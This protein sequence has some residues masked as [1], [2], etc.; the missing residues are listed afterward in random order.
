MEDIDNFLKMN[1]RSGLVDIAPL[2]KELGKR[3]H[4]KCTGC[5]ANAFFEAFSRFVRSVLDGDIKLRDN[6]YRKWMECRIRCFGRYAGIAEPGIDGRLLRDMN[7]CHDI[8]KNGIMEPIVFVRESD[9]F[10][11]D[12]YHRMVVWHELGN[13]EIRYLEG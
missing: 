7:L 9:G 1:A 10:E 2:K 6:P 4:S 3:F 13:D 12:G 5:D 8:R 11:I